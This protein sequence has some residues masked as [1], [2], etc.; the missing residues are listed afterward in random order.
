MINAAR[1][2]HDGSDEF[3]LLRAIRELG[4]F[5]AEYGSDSTKDARRWASGPCQIVCIDNWDHWVAIRGTHGGLFEML[6]SENSKKNR[7]ESGQWDLTWQ[8]LLRRWRAAA[9][10]QTDKT[11]RTFYGI[12][13]YQNAPDD[14]P[15][16]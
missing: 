5:Y 3:N 6:D 4:F 12:A 9:R 1:P 8:K 13:I 10:V 11:D 15:D 2:D 14:K 16:L 7:V